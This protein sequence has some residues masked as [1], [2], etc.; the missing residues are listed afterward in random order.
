LEE[1]KSNIELLKEFATKT[2][3]EI[4]W[5]EEE[6]P[7]SVYR[8]IPRYRRSVYISGNK[9]NT[10]YYVLFSDPYHKVGEDTV[11]CG[12]FIPLPFQLEGKINIR[13][14]NIFDKLQLFKKKA[15]EDF[16][17]R[18]FLSKAVVSYENEADL[19]QLLKNVTTQDKLVESLGNSDMNVI[20]VNEYDVDFIPELTG[21][22]CLGFINP[23]FWEVEDKE[24]ERYF[25]IAERLK[26]YL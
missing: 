17:S 7:V 20:S 10:F 8:K 4:V 15:G 12:A 3:R 9:N 6:Y 16:L 23:R 21:K 18:R 26:T 13:R 14:K 22:S 19:K 5:K 25:K 1:E 24:I 11:F 2:N